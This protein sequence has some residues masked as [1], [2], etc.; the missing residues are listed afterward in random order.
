MQNGETALQKVGHLAAMDYAAREDGRAMAT[1]LFSCSEPSVGCV[2]V[3][4]AFG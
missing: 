1:K 2:L 4:G 3:A